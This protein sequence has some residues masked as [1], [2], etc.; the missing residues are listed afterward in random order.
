MAHANEKPMAAALLMAL[1][2]TL[3]AP[4]SRTARAADDSE[5]P[6]ALVRAGRYEPLYPP[7]PGVRTL[8]VSAFWLMTRPVTNREYLAFT[9]SH[10]EYRRDRIARVFADIG[11]L[12]HWASP[13]ALGEPARPEQPVTRVS[14]FGAKAYCAAAGLRLP[15]EAEWELAAAASATSRDARADPELRRSQLAWYAKPNDEL[16]DVPH[17][18]ANVYGIRDLHG[19]IWEWVLDFNNAISVADSRE[20]GDSTQ[21]RFCGGGALLASDATNYPAFMR[22]AMRS[23]LQ[24]SYTSHLLGFRCAKDAGRSKGKSP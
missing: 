1:L 21:D 16:P 9:E 3:Y 18:P 20:Q 11:Y 7:A 6:L 17:G 14:W 22:A 15:T 23:S 24:A 8:D 12:S 5:P 13:R 2:A 19:V 10:P 4:C